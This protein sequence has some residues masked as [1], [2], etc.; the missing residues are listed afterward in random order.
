MD[1]IE[2][3]RGCIDK[4]GLLASGDKVIVSV[5]G[6]PDSLTLLHLLWR[7]RFDYDLQLHVFHLDHMFRG[8]ESAADAEFVVEFAAKLEVPV[9]IKEYDVAEYINSKKGL[10]KQAAAREIRYRFCL[11]LAEQLEADKIAIG[12]HADD[13]AET[14]LINFLRGAGLTGLSGIAPLRNDK[15]IRPLLEVWRV[16]IEKYCSKHDLN[17]R[18]DSS[19][20]EAIYLRNKV[21]LELLPYLER[22]FNSSI[23][24][25]LNRMAKLFR[26]EEDFLEKHAATKYTQS[27]LIDKSERIDLDLETLQSLDLAILR[28]V[29]RQ[30]IKEFTGDKKDYYFQHIEQIIELIKEG[31]TGSLLQLPQGLR[32]KR[33]YKTL[34]LTWQERLKQDIK[35]FE[36][37]FTVPGQ[38][39]VTEL[40]VKISFNFELAIFFNK[41]RLTKD[42]KKLFL[43]ASLIG[44]QVIVRNRRA[45]D[46]F[47]PL[48]MEGTK[49]IKDF[50]ID[51]K[52]AQEVRDKVPI[53]TTLKGVIFAVGDFRIEDSFKV[54]EKTEEIL[55]LEV[56]Y[57]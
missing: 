39:T 24:E 46:R 7:L 17:P 4:Y 48:G 14:V 40:G 33:I 20:L 30:A 25:S 3:V 18:L 38:Y 32:V 19:N 55:V 53:F 37:V 6:G 42:S 15:F 2:R 56:E 36:T 9:T 49:K 52:I 54:T 27:L 28:R 43:D 29:I 12:Q 1:L 41:K 22:E 44:E 26:E 45:G 16:D 21:R 34:R 10:S 50:F 5:S 35:E 11:E 31:I 23:K 13:Q 57:I 47:C 8:Q 51:E